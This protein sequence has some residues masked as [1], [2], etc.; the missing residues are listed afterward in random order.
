[1]YLAHLDKTTNREQTLTQHCANVAALCRKYGEEIQC[2]NLAELCGLLHDMGKAKE[3]FQTYLKSD[4]KSLRGKIN[5]SAAGAKY[6]WEKYAA[7]GL[8]EK[9]TAQIISLV[10][11]SHHSGLIDCIDPHGTD[12]FSERVNPKK[13]IHFL[14]TQTGFLNKDISEKIA[15]LYTL[16]VD[17]LKHINEKITDKKNAPF[18][19]GLLTRYLLSCVIDADRY[20]TCCFAANRETTENT[21]FHEWDLLIQ[22]LEEKLASFT[23]DTPIEKTRAAISETCKN[24]AQNPTGIYRLNVP[25]GG[26]KTLS[27]LRFALNH[28]KEQKKTRIVYAIPYTTIIDQNAE[29]IHQTLKKDEIILE[30]HSNIIRENS[31]TQPEEVNRVNLLTERWDS[32][33]ILTTTVQMLNTL[34]LGKTSS[35]RRMHNLANSIL[36]FDEVQSLPVKT[37]SMFNTSM[38][39]LSEICGTTI[40][41]CTATQPELTSLQKPIRLSQPPD[42]VSNLTDIFQAFRR[43]NIYNA[44]R[45]KGYNTAE[46]AD[47]VLDK[48]NNNTLIILNTKTA[49]KNL[50]I[51][52]ENRNHQSDIYLLSTNLCPK[53]RM[54]ILHE[55]TDRLKNSS[56][57]LICVSTQLIEAGVDISFETVIRS[58][59]GLDSISQAAGRCNRHG[60]AKTGNVYIINSTEEKLKLMPEIIAGQKHTKRVLRDFEQNPAEF[61]NDLLSPKAIQRYYTYSFEETEKSTFDYLIPKKKTDL[62]ED[63]TLYDILSRNQ[64]GIKAATPKPSYILTQSFAAAG[65]L[66]KVIDENT[67]SVIVPYGEGK[68]LIQKLRTTTDLRQ[69]RHLLQSAQQYAINL[70]LQENALEYNGIYPINDTGILELDETAYSQ[71]YGF[72]PSADIMP[73][74]M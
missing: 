45:D 44:T 32:P 8:F 13:D 10:I 50:C 18:Y 7:A 43:T 46:L 63:I 4:D 36:I 35:I 68:E 51:Q 27:S 17:E 24:F 49:A 26:G 25:T 14:E 72:S 1:M 3:E 11:C 58:L 69:L 33:I 16:A 57:P 29:V 48:H 61:D 9:L 66:F 52:L 20:D 62:S 34:F 30:H 28:A 15:S 41:L 12:N 19:Y 64:T 74:I 65:N 21:P 55:I 54:E 70:F 59:A 37:L 5:H 39:F 22:N 6:I 53:H 67:I 40:I 47:F 56:R 31:D 42:I 23:A 73:I 38:N 60:N 2:P 71:K